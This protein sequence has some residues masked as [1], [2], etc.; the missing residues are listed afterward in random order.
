MGL[1]SRFRFVVLSAGDLCTNRRQ[2][3]LE[4]GV[5]CGG[6]CATICRMSACGTFRAAG[7]PVCVAVASTRGVGRYGPPLLSPRNCPRA[8]SSPFDGPS[9]RSGLRVPPP[10]VST[11]GG[12]CRSKDSG[13]P[14]SP[15]PA[16]PPPK[17]KTQ[18]RVTREVRIGQAGRGRAPAGERPMGAAGYGG[19]GFTGRARVSGER[20]I[21]AARCRQQRD[22]ASCQAPFPPPPPRPP[23]RAQSRRPQM[24]GQFTRRLVGVERASVRASIR[25]SYH[26]PSQGSVGCGALQTRASADLDICAP[27]GGRCRW[28][29][30]GA[31][32]KAVTN[33]LA[34]SVT[35]GT[36]DCPS[37][38]RPRQCH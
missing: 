3:T 29:T 25:R 5:D 18:G 13:E 16:P 26:S 19:R 14:G 6:P 28:T 38:R 22:R 35:G 32:A 4:E 2:D 1:E 37:E 31:Q 10:R 9:A 7:R 11:C 33:S 24:V 36:L 8:E 30:S 27:S 34:P 20:S 15:R 12:L 17:K 21:G 23:G